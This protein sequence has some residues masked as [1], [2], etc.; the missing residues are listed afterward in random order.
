MKTKKLYEEIGMIGDDIINDVENMKHI[1]KKN[2]WYKFSAIAACLCI[3]V[4]SAFAFLPN[5]FNSKTHLNWPIKEMPTT[6][7]TE[8]TAPVPKWNDLG[9]SQQYN[10]L[11]FE[12]KTYYGTISKIDKDKLGGSIGDETLSGQD[13][14]TDEIKYKDGTLYSINGIATKCAIAVQ[15]NGDQ[16]YYV[17]R[18]SGYK[19]ATLGQFINDL[20]LRNNLS[21]GSVWYDHQKEN[22]EYATIEFVN[23][24]NS[25][26]WDMLLADESIRNVEDYDSMW[27]NS[28]MSVSVNIHLLGYEK[29][30]LSVTDNG[31]ITTNILDTGKAFFIGEDKVKE[32]VDYVI[33]NCDGYEIVYVDT[34][35]I[36]E[37]E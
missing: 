16:D 34:E 36:G 21:F 28:V 8:N 14:Y 3:V 31:Y 15:F 24:E 10:Q 6:Q 1:H 33:E 29:I 20:N 18:N 35:D 30:S 32:F 22:G 9:I 2:S 17:Y 23:L 12:N 13:N 19:P 26:V 7:L 27:F 5:F 4:V 37:P 11:T 25:V